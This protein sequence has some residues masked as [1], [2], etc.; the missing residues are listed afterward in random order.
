ML[1]AFVTKPDADL[2]AGKGYVRERTI[3]EKY[4]P[5]ALIQSLSLAKLRTP[6]K[7][8]L[9]HRA[10]IPGTRPGTEPATINRAHALTA[11]QRPFALQ[12]AKT[13]L[14]SAAQCLFPI[15]RLAPCE[16]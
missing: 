16:L 9:S 7:F 10:G 14:L 15:D 12:K 1:S 11:R 5:E 4:V 8:P 6:E 3:C 2:G 13:D